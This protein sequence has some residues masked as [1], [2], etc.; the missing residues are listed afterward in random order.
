MATLM[1]STPLARSAARFRSRSANRYGGMLRIRRATSIGISSA[2]LRASD[3]GPAS[4][5]DH[6]T[7]SFGHH[8]WRIVLDLQP[9]VARVPADPG[10]LSL[11]IAPGIALQ[12]RP[13]LRQ[14]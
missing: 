1:T 6:S 10:Q 11:G 4:H 3:R 13:G 2:R 8:L 12:Q 9:A 14:R 5:S 7:D